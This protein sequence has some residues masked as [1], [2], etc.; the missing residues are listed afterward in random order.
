MGMTERQREA[1]RREHRRYYAR[2]A[3]RYKPRPWS[4]KEDA[5]VLAHD[6]PDSE[7]S[8]RIG[9]SMKAI[10]NRRWRLKGGRA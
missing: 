7:L 6:V 5:V 3:F 8:L 10:S 2:T 1:K 9:R 4:E